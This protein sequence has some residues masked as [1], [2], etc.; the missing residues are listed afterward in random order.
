MDIFLLSG[1]IAGVSILL[2]FVNGEDEFD[3][4]VLSKAMREG[5]IGR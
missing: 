5:T 3:R 2:S 1:R 4:I